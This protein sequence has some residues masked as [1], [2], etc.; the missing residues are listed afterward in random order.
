[1]EIVGIGNALMDAIAF[2]DEDFAPSLGFHN[3]ATVHMESSR[4][5]SILSRIPDMMSNA[6]GGA[7]NTLRV[8][9]LLGAHASF[10][11]A[12][13][14]DL[15]GQSYRGDLAAAGV[16]LFMM[17]SP[18]PTGFFVSLVRPDGG[19]TVLVAPGAALDVTRCEPPAAIFSPGAF[20][21]LE[22]FLLRD[23][24]FFV[25]CLEAARAARMRLAIDL[26]SFS[27]VE[28][29]REFIL[30]LLGDYCDYLFANEDEFCSLAGLPLAE[31]LD[32]LADSGPAI[33]VK[34]SERGAL[35][36]K[37]EAKLESPVRAIYPV[38][39]TGS[40][41]AFAAGYLSAVAQGLPPE[42]CL[43]LGNRIAE[44]VLLVPG[45]AVDPDRI[46]RAFDSVSE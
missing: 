5:S 44:E 20:L 35:Y 18:E 41:D 12:V 11:G 33:I 6:G 4:L 36:V 45:L 28:S 39:E 27:L 7:A 38:D 46:V 29:E 32:L 2:V 22:G 14:E 42:R 3:G 25:S 17:P 9:S 15:A 16:G 1:M 8:A 21:Y 13:G 19:R 30:E 31:G 37:G 43:R 10:V 24:S 23:R 40:G 26:G 34:R